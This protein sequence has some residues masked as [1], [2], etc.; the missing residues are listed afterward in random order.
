MK[1]QEAGENCMIRVSNQ[2][3]QNIKNI[4]HVWRR[5]EMRTK[6]FILKSEGK[7]P[8]GRSRLRLGDNIKIYFKE[9]RW[10]E[11]IHLRMGTGF[12]LL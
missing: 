6:F 4:E 12:W 2:G 10:I 8:F 5:T 11:M 1:W 3:E 9:I 7:I